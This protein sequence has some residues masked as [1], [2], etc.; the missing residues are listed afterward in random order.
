M[1]L[2]RHRAEGQWLADD[3]PLSLTASGRGNGVDRQDA[4]LVVYGRRE[5]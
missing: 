4:L 5:G 2:P 3:N 1:S